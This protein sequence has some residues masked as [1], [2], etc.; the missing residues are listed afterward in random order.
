MTE[1]SLVERRLGDDPRNYV[2]IWM[3]IAGK[4]I[5]LISHVCPHFEE[6][7]AFC[8]IRLFA[9]EDWLNKHASDN[10][11]LVGV[12]GGE[13]DEHPTANEERT[14][15][16]CAATLIAESLGIDSDPTLKPLLDFVF[17]RDTKK[18]EERFDLAHVVKALNRKFEDKPIIVLR[19]VFMALGALREEEE[20]QLGEKRFYFSHV[21]EA[22]DRK[23]GNNPIKVLWWAKLTMDALYQE[24]RDLI[25]AGE[26]F[27]S[28]AQIEEIPIDNKRVARLVTVK[29][30]DDQMRAFA[31]SP[32]GGKA[33][34]LVLQQPS[35]N[36]QIFLSRN[37]G[38]GFKSWEA[39]KVV[40][41]I[42]RMLRIREQEISGRVI[43]TTWADLEKEGFVPGVNTWYFHP[44]G[45]F[46]LNG[47]L[48]RPHP[49]PTRLT[50]EQIQEIVR[51]AMD[52]NGLEPSRAQHCLGGE[53]AFTPANE[54]QC[55]LRR[56]G[57]KR[58]ATTRS[59]ARQQQENNN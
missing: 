26:K 11:V 23:Y 20:N 42:I 17:K 36:T 43:T 50:L 25:K 7:V 27:S 9:D 48:T 31:L 38:F 15:G 2:L 33:T 16:H 44:E 29:S 8:L 14:K 3:K 21:L 58:C 56:F 34:V 41:D 30:G 45:L 40:Q 55:P 12:G 51:I 47:C 6:Y 37:G 46:I 32:N 54:N 49:I 52:I 53:C 18:G 10:L 22:V 57:L 24:E 13:F 59:R 4:L 1:R 28:A 5:G 39:T 35:G 19:W